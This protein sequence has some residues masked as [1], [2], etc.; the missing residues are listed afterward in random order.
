TLYKV[1]IN[2][3]DLTTITS[4]RAINPYNLK[5]YID[6]AIKQSSNKYIYKLKTLSIN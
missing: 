6:Y 1:I 5:V 2:I 3:R 4:I